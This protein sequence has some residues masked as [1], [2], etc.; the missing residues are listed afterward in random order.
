MTEIQGK[1]ILLRVSEGSGVN[2]SFFC[3]C[4]RQLVA[5]RTVI[6]SKAY[7]PLVTAYK[8]KYLFVPLLVFS[9]FFFFVGKYYESLT[10]I[11]TSGATSV[12]L[13]YVQLSDYH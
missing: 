5:G 1:S 8:M 12:Y 13:K 10:S 2:C 7:A 9:T 11:L 4:L 6:N 3:N